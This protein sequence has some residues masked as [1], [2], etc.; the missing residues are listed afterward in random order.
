MNDVLSGNFTPKKNVKAAVAEDD[1]EEKLSARHASAS[2]DPSPSFRRKRSTGPSTK[3]K[4]TTN[5]N[6]VGTSTSMTTQP[7]QAI[8]GAVAW[9]LLDRMEEM[10]WD[11]HAALSQENAAGNAP[12]FPKASLWLHC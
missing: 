5:R 11:R 10:T 1:A 3:A 9:E 4:R 8:G 12:G 2:V 7:L 6:T